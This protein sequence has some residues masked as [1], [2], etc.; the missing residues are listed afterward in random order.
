V[1]YTAIGWYGGTSIS[2][3]R[4]LAFYECITRVHSRTDRDRNK[5]SQAERW[6]ATQ[7]AARIEHQLNESNVNRGVGALYS[8]WSQWRARRRHDQ[9]GVPSQL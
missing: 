1:I 5:S 9:Q 4:S 8:L 2:V 6:N 7:R 3:V